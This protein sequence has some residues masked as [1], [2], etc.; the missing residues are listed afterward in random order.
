MNAP[1]TALVLVLAALVSGCR[2][3]EAAPRARL[4]VAE[5]LSAGAEGYARAVEPR[6]FRF[7]EDHGPH[8]RFRTEWWYLTGNLAAEDGRRFGIQL[9][10]F[11]NALT[12]P[13]ED[14][15][16]TAPA[17][18][19]SAWA[20]R[21]T[22]FAHFALTDVAAGRFVSAERLVRGAVGLAGAEVRS[23]HGEGTS[24]L[25]L[26]VADWTARTVPAGAAP[27]PAAAGLLP[28]RLRAAD[29]AQEKGIGI[30]LVLRPDKPPVAHGEGGLSRKGGG[31]GN[32]SYYYSFTRLPAEGTVVTGGERVAV[33]GRLWMDREWST[34]ALTPEQQGWDWFSLQ[35]DDGRDLMVYALRLRSETSAERAGDV[36]RVL[37]SASSGTLVEPDGTA[38]HLELSDVEIEPIDR[39]Q[40]PRSGAVYPI[41]WRLRV[42]DAGI[43]LMI[44]TPVE[45]QELDVGFRYWEGAVTAEGT[46]ADRP[47]SGRGYVELTGYDASRDENPG[48]RSAY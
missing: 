41:R 44:A 43:D 24:G 19:P 27:G 46:S 6:S 32:A 3:R 35:L 31:P 13:P 9:T 5:A 36:E 11:R 1:R 20:T 2:D 28:L 14:V 45:D 7:P 22:W 30:D 26:W 23:E 33:T 16:Q 37:D 47:V 38:R 18:R 21:Q 8:P 29:G 48:R 12:P 42:P 4:S 10:F 15:T 34:S 40:S 17:D 25:D 39:W